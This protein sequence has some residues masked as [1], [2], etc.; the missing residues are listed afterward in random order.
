MT[1]GSPFF[2]LIAGVLSILSPCVLP[3]LPIVLGTAA[4]HHR[5]GPLALASGLS[6]S[7]VAIGL[8]LA[9]VGFSIGLDAERLRYVAAALIMIIGTL[10]IFPPLQARLALAAG[11]VGNW[12]GGKLETSTGGGISGQFWVGVLLGAVW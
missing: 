8:F 7:F 11:P 12:A 9:T 5:F 3:I 1:V 4:S 2:A 10:L 6:I